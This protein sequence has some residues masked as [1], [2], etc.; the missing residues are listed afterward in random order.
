MMQNTSD[1]LRSERALCQE[2]CIA[3]SHRF[4]ATWLSDQ[5]IYS[6]QHEAT[7]VVTLEEF[8][9]VDTMGRFL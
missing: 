1:L 6:Y 4:F 3:R 8:V 9:E 7:E 5:H 2:C